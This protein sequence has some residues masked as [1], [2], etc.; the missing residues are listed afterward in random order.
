[1]MPTPAAAFSLPIPL[2]ALETI[3]ACIERV[4]G[5]GDT[6]MHMDGGFLQVAAPT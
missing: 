6:L 5:T 3:R 1:M 4:Y 2:D